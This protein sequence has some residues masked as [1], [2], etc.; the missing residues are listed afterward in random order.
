VKLILCYMIYTEEMWMQKLN[1]Y[2][3]TS[4]GRLFKN[5]NIYILIKDLEV[6]PRPDV[7]VCCFIIKYL[8]HK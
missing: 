7:P 1:G 4:I 6:F 3:I 8:F 5:R 2:Y